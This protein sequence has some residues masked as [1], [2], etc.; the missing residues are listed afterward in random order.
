MRLPLAAALLVSLGALPAPAR[1]TDLVFAATLPPGVADVA[2]W[3][4]VTGDFETPKLRG[5]YRLYVNPARLALYQVMRYR[6]Q[7]L[8]S[9]AGPG[10]ATL[11]AE[12]VVFVRRPGV[13]EPVEC[14]ERR[15]PGSAPEWRALA[16]GT[17]EYVAEMAQLTE[18]LAIHRAARSGP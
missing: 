14:W 1:A 6:V 8:P 18:V 7:R 10:D 12:R 11:R 5:A 17:G 3:E 2:G 9:S 15:A 4:L 16:P 13:R